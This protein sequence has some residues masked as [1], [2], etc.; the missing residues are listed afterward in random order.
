MVFDDREVEEVKALAREMSRRGG[1]AVFAVRNAE[2]ATLVYAASIHPSDFDAGRLLKETMA[3]F[4]GRGGG[5]E[6]MAQGALADPATAE[7]AVRWAAER[8]IE[9]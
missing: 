6:L 9:G 2:R 1:H 5:S 3:K 4:G 7:A 8:I